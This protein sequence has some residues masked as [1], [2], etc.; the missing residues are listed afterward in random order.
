LSPPNREEILERIEKAREEQHRA[1]E[2]RALQGKGLGWDEIGLVVEG[3]AFG[4]RPIRAAAREVTE[5]FGLGPRGA[6]ILSLISSGICYPLELA[7]ALK[8][9]RSLVTAELDKL[10]DAGLVTATPGAEDRRRSR[11]A[12]TPAGEAACEEVRGTMQRIVT[13]NLAGYSP[14]EVRLFI[15]MLRDVR[16]LEDNEAEPPC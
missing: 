5:R 15:R 8:I 11:L 9:G 7:T 3:L 12:L 16:R 6:F 1:T 14:E 10:R 2:V 4:Q 13:R